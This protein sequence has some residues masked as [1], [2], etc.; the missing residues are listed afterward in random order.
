MQFVLIFDFYFFDKH[1][2]IQCVKEEKFGYHIFK[3]FVPHNWF[4][5]V[6]DTETVSSLEGENQTLRNIFS[7]C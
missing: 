4:Q 1:L 7:K 5:F 6:N 3:D 2:F